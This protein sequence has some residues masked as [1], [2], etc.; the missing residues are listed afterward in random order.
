MEYNTFTKHK[1]NSSVKD[2]IK[3]PFKETDDST[4]S[5]SSKTTTT[6]RNDSNN[7]SGIVAESPLMDYI[8][9][10]KRRRIDNPSPQD[11]TN[12]VKNM[13]DPPVSNDEFSAAVHND[14]DSTLKSPFWTSGMKLKFKI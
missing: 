14:S 13:R 8:T 2:V 3:K 4:G 9:F 1:P 5:N 10:T 11:S 7:S 12:I 6:S